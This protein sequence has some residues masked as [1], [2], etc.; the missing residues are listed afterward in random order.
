MEAPVPSGRAATTVSLSARS[1]DTEAVV[2][3]ATDDDGAPVVGRAGIVRTARI[4]MD[5]VAYP[6]SYP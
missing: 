2:D 6:R 5:G 4:L 1:E 3:V